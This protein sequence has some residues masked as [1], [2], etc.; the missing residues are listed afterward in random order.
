MKLK[1][2][3]PVIILTAVVVLLVIFLNVF[4]LFMLPGWINDQW[5]VLYFA[6][7]WLILFALLIQGMAARNG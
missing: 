3:T 1:H 7:Y 5:G 2:T 6:W 4:F